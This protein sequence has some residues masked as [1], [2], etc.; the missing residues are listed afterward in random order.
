MKVLIAMS[1][2]V[3]S[4][5]TAAL[6]LE[7]GHTAEGCTLRLSGTEREEAELARAAASAEVLGIPHRVLDLR[8]EFAR[9]VIRPFA[10][11]YA[12]GRTPNPC[13]LCNKKIKLGALYR[14]AM[15]EG[16]DAI[17]TGHYARIEMKDGRPH[18]LRALDGAK[19][20]SYVLYTL[21]EEVLAHTLLPLGGI[22]KREARAIAEECGLASA[23]AEESQDICF[24]PNGRY[25]EVVEGVLGTPIPEGSY[26]DSEGRILGRHRGITHYTIGQHKGLG[27]A[28]GRVRYVTRIDAARGEVTLG[29]EEDL[30]TREVRLCDVH[31]IGD[32]PTFPIPV[33]V[34]LRYR[35]RDV[36]ATLIP[37]EGG[38]R[39]LTDLPVRAPAPGQSAVLYDGE[40]VLGGGIIL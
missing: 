40:R 12:Q 15:A 37:E 29:D 20:Q 13:I 33:T 31:F 2:G 9:E 5:A 18:L 34:K 32:V 23:R 22:T 27:I 30:F 8:E 11:A 1:G 6:I 10:E 21:T 16:F 7:A 25:A 39:L 28:L 14:Y 17:A 4:A 38:A 26:V 36:S 19:D 35:Q 24:V 3:D